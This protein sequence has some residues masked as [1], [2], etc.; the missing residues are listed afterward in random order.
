MPL[1]FLLPLL[2]GQ[3]AVLEHRAGRGVAPHL[4]DDDDVLAADG[5]RQLRDVLDLRP[6]RVP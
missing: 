3:V 5:G 2:G 1:V 6:H 4:G